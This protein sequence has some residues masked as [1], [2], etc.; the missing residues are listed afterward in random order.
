MMRNSCTKKIVLCGIFAALIGVGA[1]IQIPI[2]LIPLSLQDLFVMLAGILIGGKYGALSVLI[3][4]C[5]GLLGFP[6][7]TRG[8]GITYVLQPTFGFMLGFIPGAYLTGWL[9]NKEEEPGFGRIFGACIAGIGVIYFFGTVYL[10]L[11][12]R[13]YLGNSI[14]LWPMIVACDIRPLPGD[15]I[16]SIIA[17]KIGHQLLPLIRKG[18]I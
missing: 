2:P 14:A 7:F 3:Y 4:I 18:V 11:L 5:V 16:K 13:F 15:I 12:N 9:S 1:F 17:A 8:G 6:V 10:Y